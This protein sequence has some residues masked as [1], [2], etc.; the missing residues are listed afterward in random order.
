MGMAL[1][2]LFLL[3]SPVRSWMP[4]VAGIA[5]AVVLAALLLARARPRSGLS[6]RARALRTARS[7][8]HDGLLAP[9]I[10]PRVVLASAAAVTGHIGTFLIAAHAAGSHAPLTVL[11]PLALLALV[12]M[13]LPASVG[14]FG[15]REGV[16]AWAFAAAGLTAAQGITT[17]VL[18]GVLVLVASL[19]G[20]AVL[21]VRRLRPPAVPTGGAGVD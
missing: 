13:T 19:P 8:I 6:R 9:R 14:G 1:V 2:V 12:V 20:A 4:A 3:P 21:L 18:Y 5:V 7:D 10:W 17:A 11:V 15:P 16:A